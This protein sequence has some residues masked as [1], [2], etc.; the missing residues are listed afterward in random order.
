MPY[1]VDSS[2]PLEDRHMTMDDLPYYFLSLILLYDLL[3][4]P[5]VYHHTEDYQIELILDYNID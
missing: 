5:Y 1:Y 2:M 4:K 3:K